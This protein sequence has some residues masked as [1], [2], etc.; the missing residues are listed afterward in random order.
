MSVLTRLATPVSIAALL[1]VGMP[2]TAQAAPDVKPHIIGGVEATIEEAPWQVGLMFFGAENPRSATGCGGSVISAEWVVTA[3]HCVDFLTS[4]GDLQVTA[5][6]TTLP[7]SDTASVPRYAVERILINPEWNSTS[8]YADIALVELATPLPIDGVTIAPIG[9]PTFTSWPARGT[10]ALITGW[11][12][13]R[14]QTDPAYLPTLRKADISVLAGPNDPRCGDYPAS[15]AP[16]GYDPEVMLCAGKETPPLI[17]ACQGDSGGPL[18]IQRDGQWWLAGITSWGNGCAEPGFP[19]IYTRVTA[20]TDWIR[21]AQAEGATGSITVTATGSA[22]VTC[23]YVYNAEAGAGPV[24]ARCAEPGSSITVPDVFPGDYLVRNTFEGRYASETWVSTSGATLQRASASS[25][26]VA[27]GRAASATNSTIAGT[28]MSFT[29]PSAASTLGDNLCVFV[30]AISEDLERANCL[31]RGST[32]LDVTSV[33]PSADGY[34]ITVTEATLTFASYYYTGP[35][36]TGSLAFEQAEAVTSAI[37]T[38]TS[39][40]LTLSRAARISGTVALG[41]GGDPGGLVELTVVGIAD[42]VLVVEVGSDGTYSMTGLPPG[43][44]EVGALD[45]EGLHKRQWWQDAPSRETATPLSVTAG[46]STT[47]INMRL[48]AAGVISGTVTGPRGAA[49]AAEAYVS[50]ILYR[51]DA[52]VESTPVAADGTYFFGALDAGDY[53][54]DFRDEGGVYY[55]EFYGG[56]PD[57]AGARVV[58]VV[59]GEETA[60]VDMALTLIQRIEITASRTGQGAKSQIVVKGTTTGLAGSRVTPWIK[61]A[62]AKRFAAAKPVRVRADGTFTWTYRTSKAASVYVKA[63]SMRSATVRVGAAARR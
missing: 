17:D 25:I 51:D 16:S 20:F 18:A 46:S 7:D 57:L 26:R 22:P 39:I 33:P 44:Y 34:L 24:A 28:A 8:N 53:K 31:R 40:S 50:A 55:S 21:S 59:A 54:V 41:E 30:Y 9:L 58:R 19:G 27:G 43:S 10:T 52:R 49:L 12:N 13:S 5:G 15:P 1:A 45:L 37:N 48:E 29:L 47:G 23:A 63:G 35:G 56:S 4:P 11:G 36:Q 60:G 2:A 3:A 62:G 14:S 6:V 38:T 42:P 61:V 32:S